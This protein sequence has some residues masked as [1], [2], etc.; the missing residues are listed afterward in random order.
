[1]IQDKAMMARLT[2]CQWTGRKQ[3]KKVTDE[4]EKAHGAKDAGRFNKDLVD[5][6]LLEPISKLAGA[7]RDYHYHVTLAWSDNGDRILPSALFLSY[8][9]AMRKFKSDFEAAV[10]N[11]LA[12]YP[13]EVHAARQRLGTMYD[14]GDY[15]DVGM[16]GSKFSL[17]TEFNPIPSAS[18]FR[19][20]IDV[21]ARESIQTEIESRVVERQAQAVKSTLARVK[22]VVD[23]MHE[24]LADPKAIFRDSLV[25]NVSDLRQI[26]LGLNIT[27]NSLINELAEEMKGLEEPPGALRSNGTLRQRVADR[28]L[29][30]LNKLP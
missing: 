18:D 30:I 2:V 27:N 7:A 8:T 28:A 21:E 9:Q 24:K 16:L 15:P 29:A 14:P 19:V 10:A 17:T 20:E 23:K 1:M 25:T 13:T 6:A 22:D 12:K 5:R 4:I 26:L 11:M 3:D